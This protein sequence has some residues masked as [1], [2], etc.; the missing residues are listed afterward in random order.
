MGK[1]IP[2]NIKNG[3]PFSEAREKLKRYSLNGSNGQVRVKVL[4]FNHGVDVNGN[5]IAHY[6]VMLIIENET[7]EINALGIVESGSRREQVGY[8][9]EN[10]AALYALE[11]L[12]YILKYVSG[13]KGAY[14]EPIYYK[15]LNLWD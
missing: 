10:E 6:R 13:G 2:K 14:D 11:K 7:L 3:V 1:H 15:I 4:T 5:V 8:S 12:G 9:K